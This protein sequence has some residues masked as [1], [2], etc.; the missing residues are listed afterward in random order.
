[1]QIQEHKA[2]NDKGY[3]V[4][5]IEQLEIALPE[6]PADFVVPKDEYAEQSL[7][8]LWDAI[9]KSKSEW[10]HTKA[11]SAFWGRISYILLG[12]PL[13]ILGLPTLLYVY[14]KWGRDLYI[15]IPASCGIAFFA[16]GVWGALQSLAGAG[17]LSPFVAAS[18]IHIIFTTVGLLLLRRE[19]R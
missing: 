4:R 10:Q 15:A 2:D 12:L 7:T 17:H 1:M 18:T 5:N 9:V 8:G 19:D 16:W 6:K 11:A 3:Q 14:D 13:L